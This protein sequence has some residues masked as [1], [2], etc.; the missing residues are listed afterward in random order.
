V[1]VL[2]GVPTWADGTGA[3]VW[4]RATDAAAATAPTVPARTVRRDS[5]APD[6]MSC[7]LPVYQPVR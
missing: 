4:A 2:A 5:V 1:I 3:E 6:A 7:L